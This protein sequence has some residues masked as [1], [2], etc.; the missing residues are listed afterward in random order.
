MAVGRLIRRSCPHL[1]DTEAAAYD[2]PFPDARFKAGV[3]RFPNMVPDRPDAPGAE[4]AEGVLLEARVHH[5]PMIALTTM[6]PTASGKS[7]S[8]LK[9]VNRPK[10]TGRP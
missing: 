7:L 6:T 5:Q 3:R 8:E 2:A 10:S 4:L 1:T 9:F